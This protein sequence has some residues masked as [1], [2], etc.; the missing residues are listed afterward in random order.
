MENE[1]ERFNKREALRL[2]FEGK[3]VTDSIKVYK[4]TNDGDL[5][6]SVSVYYGIGVMEWY[7]VEDWN[8]LY[9]YEFTIFEPEKTKKK[10]MYYRPDILKDHSTG[11]ILKNRNNIFE[12][13]KDKFELQGI[14]K[15]YKIISW[16]EI[17]VYE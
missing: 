14:Y 2:M 4:I 16:E 9:D 8:K 6:Y 13:H 5:K 10:V 15:D 1:V 3:L 17:G 12:K 7:D 11:D